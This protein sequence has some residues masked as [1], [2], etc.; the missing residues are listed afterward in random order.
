MTVVINIAVLLSEPPSILHC[1]GKTLTPAWNSC[2][3]LISSSITALFQRN[4]T[5]A[6]TVFTMPRMRSYF[7]ALAR[8]RQH[9]NKEPVPARITAR[10]PVPLDPERPSLVQLPCHIVLRILSFVQDSSPGDVCE[11]AALSSTL[12]Q[13]ARYVQYQT[14]YIDLDQSRLAR[15][16]LN[17]LSR[18]LLLPAVRSLEV[19]GSKQNIQMQDEDEGNEILTLLANMFPGMTGLRDLHWQV[20]LKRNIPLPLKTKATVPLPLSII[21]HLSSRVRLHTSVTCEDTTNAMNQGEAREFLLQLADNQ[22]LFSLSVQISFFD[23]LECR[24]TMRALKHVLLSCPNLA[25]IPLLNVW[26]PCGPAYHGMAGGPMPGSPYCGLGLSDGERPPALEELGIGRYPWGHE[27]SEPF[28]SIYC[29]GYPGKGNEKHYWAE[30]FDWSQLQ[31]INGIDSDMALEIA[32]KMTHLKEVVTEFECAAFLEEIPTALKLLNI[33]SWSHVDCR[34]DPITRHGAE[35]RMLKIHRAEHQWTTDSLVTDKDL[36]DLC[37][38]LPHLEEL[39]IDISRDQKAKDWPYSS[40]EIIARFPSI[41]IVQLWFE[42]GTGH[43]TPPTPP[44]TV[45]AAR[46]LFEYLRE[47]NKKIQRLELGSRAPSA[48]PYWLGDQPS[49]EVQNSMRFVCETSIYDGNAELRVTC[50]DFSK[51]MNAELGRLAAENREGRRELSKDTTGLSLKVMLDGPLSLDEWTAW[52]QY[53]LYLQTS[54]FRRSARSV[55]K[56]I[57]KL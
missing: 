14:L 34:P 50:P 16:R 41:R 1:Y 44:L 49:W 51:E 47:R 53:R 13:M 19:R 38:G 6:N 32:P 55:Q 42:L 26:Y 35:L 48:T 18:N 3:L 15:N 10:E 28:D 56:Y 43:P 2:L 8:I 27:Q 45:F 30:T 7:S 46:Q 21:R 22:N 17:F 29:F 40:L 5:T 36:V 31:R 33:P 24:E 20:R 52:H 54:I 12:Y 4:I 23:E 9:H 25:S 39:A 37:N 11:I 57:L